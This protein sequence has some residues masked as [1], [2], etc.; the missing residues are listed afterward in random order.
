MA[1]MMGNVVAKFD[2]KDNV[3]PR[4]EREQD[5]IDG[6]VALIM[7]LGLA[8]RTPEKKASKYETE[9]LAVL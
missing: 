9:G 7:A 2:A 5:K 6:P 1:W 3:Y 8:L 4:K